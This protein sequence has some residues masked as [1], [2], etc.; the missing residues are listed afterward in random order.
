VTLSRL[1]VL[2]ALVCLAALIAM[3][4]AS[5]EEVETSKPL[6]STYAWYWEEA[7]AQEFEGPQGTAAVDT[8]NEY[9]PQVPGGGLGNVSEETC[10]EGRLPIRIK[11]GDY[12]KPNQ[13]SAVMFDTLTSVPFG[14]KVKKFTAT[15]EEAK[16]GCRND[17]VA[18]SGKQCENSDPVNVEGHEL[19]ACLVTELFGEG[20]ARPYREVPGYECSDQ[21][22]TAKRKKDGD[23]Y[24]WTFD[25]TEYAQKWA[26]LDVPTS[27]VLITGV[28][29]KDTGPHDSWR[30]TLLG[31]VD[32]G[33]KATAQFVPPEDPLDT[34]SPTTVPGGDTIPG[35][36]GTPAIPGT[37]AVPG[38]AG[39]PPT[40]TDT[41]SAASGG[42][43]GASGAAEPGDAKA[44]VEA[45]E[46]AIASEPT[47]A[48]SGPPGGGLPWYGWLALLAGLAA[49]S[50]LRSVVLDGAAGIRQDGVLAH[51]QKLNAE[52]RG[53]AAAVGMTQPGLWT[54]FVGMTAGVRSAASTVGHKVSNTKV[55]GKAAGAIGKL[56]R[57]PGKR[58]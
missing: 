47:A 30:V 10:A 15:F 14:A 17:E 50:L 13:V 5:A 11:G 9:C 8:N 31:S 18:P 42:A 40:T 26:D 35:T 39:S 32:N 24:T 33:I 34:L 4:S 1:A 21:S 49:F 25:L 20:S 46:D 16:T 57:I 27:A 53:G 54:A 48:D 2:A 12:E 44:P 28:E 36:P 51:I 55:F 43:A 19:Q 22:P 7:Q 23:T 6:V 52:R 37:P 56:K 45:P 41:G 3:P 58:S 38:T 29:P